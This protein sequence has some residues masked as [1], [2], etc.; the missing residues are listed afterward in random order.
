MILLN[1]TIN[2]TTIIN[3]NEPNNTTHNYNSTTN[4]PYSMSTY[5][6]V[7]MTNTIRITTPQSG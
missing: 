7:N 5:I 3:H 1:D 2:M 6:T 4:L